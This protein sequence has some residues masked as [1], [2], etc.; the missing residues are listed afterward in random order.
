MPLPSMTSEACVIVDRLGGGF[1]YSPAYF[2]LCCV[3][4]KANTVRGSLAPV[5]H[6]AI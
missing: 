1:P 3:P 2:D 4:A 5:V 6:A